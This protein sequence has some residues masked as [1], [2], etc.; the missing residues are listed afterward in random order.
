LK[1][2]NKVSNKIIAHIRYEV[3]LINNFKAKFL[4]SMN[5]L[6]SKQVIIDISN[7]KLRFKFCK[8]NLILC[9]IKARDNVRIRRIVRT[10]K[11]KIILAKS[12]AKIAIILKEKNELFKR[13]F[14]FKFTM[15]EAY[16]HF[17]NAN[18]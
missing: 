1:S 13:D 15:L 10:T 16:T 6:K 8:K 18:F 11:K 2:E 14:L 5:I 12:I 7:R 4:I 9:E 3:H 17:V